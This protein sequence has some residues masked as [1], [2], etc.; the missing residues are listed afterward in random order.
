[1]ESNAGVTLMIMYEDESVD[2]RYKSGAQLQLSPCGCEFMLLKGRNSIGHPLEPTERV[3]QR[4]RFTVST[5][6]EMVQAALAF[7][8]KYATRPYLPEDL[9]SGDH[10]KPFVSDDSGVVWPEWSSSEAELGPGGE[11]II[12]SEDSQAVLALSPSGEEF[13]VEFTCSLSQMQ[14]QHHSMQ[15]SSRGPEGSPTVSLSSS[16]LQLQPEQI[17]QSTTVVHHLSCCALAPMWSYPLSLARHY[18]MTHFSKDVRDGETSKSSLSDS[19]IEDRRSQLPQALPLTCQLPHWHRWKIEDPL[20]KERHTEIPTELVKI[21]WCQ[22]ITYRIQRGAVSLVEIS[23]GDGSVIRSN[24][25][26]NSYFVHYKPELQSKQV[27]EVIY[28]LNSLPPDVLGQVYSV[29]SVVSRA[30]RILACYSQ[31]K[32][33]LKFPGAPSCLQEENE[34]RHFSIP[35]AHDTTLSNLVKHH[36]NVTETEDSLSDLVSAELEKIRRFNFLQENNYLL[37]NPKRHPES[38]HSSAVVTQDELVNEKCVAQALQRT[39]KA[40]KDI[41]AVISAVSLM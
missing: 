17:Y 18:W 37:C 25:G 39:S 35:S 41:D 2:I 3:R 12:R 30:S 13:S 38:E 27:K 9:V 16:P 4:T 31:A 14:H 8:N 26:L 33:L 34:E 10:K 20:T 15:S 40:I 36:M 32:Q 21:V 19:S 29:C 24:G 7:R 6:K 22:G 23:P 28:H 1:M 5:Y 11:I